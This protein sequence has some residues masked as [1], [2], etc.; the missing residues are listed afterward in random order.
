[1]GGRGSNGGKSSAAL[2]QSLSAEISE[3]WSEDPSLY[4]ALSDPSRAKDYI[5]QMKEDGWEDSE[6]KDIQQL[7][8]QIRDASETRVVK[9]INTLYRGE[10]FD[11][12]EQAQRKYSIGKSIE[13][14][15]LTSYATSKDLAT[16]Y[17][18]MY[19]KGV[20]VVITNTNTSGNF[21]G[22]GVHNNEEIIT[23]KGLKSVVKDTKF[24]KKTNTLYVTMENKATPR[25]R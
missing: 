8:N 15:Q 12:L 7:A 16:S 2:S 1:M 10:R 11:S 17:A 25:R 19:S 13:N 23:P 5:R 3:A 9:G 18:T 21:V 4:Q 14:S 6:I 20:A 22:A 24:D